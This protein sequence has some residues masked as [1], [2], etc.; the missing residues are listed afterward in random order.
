MRYR[1]FTYC[2]WDP[3]DFDHRFVKISPE[4][5][6]EQEF[7]DWKEFMRMQIQKR[8]GPSYFGEGELREAEVERLPVNAELWYLKGYYYF[9]SLLFTDEQFKNQKGLGVGPY[10][11]VLW[12][13]EVPG[14]FAA[15]L[16]KSDIK[17]YP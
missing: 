10:A 14:S 8:I 13:E 1:S 6:S 2:E 7:A 16:M 15:G 4:S 17:T 9:D 11:N 12:Y 5:L 3:R